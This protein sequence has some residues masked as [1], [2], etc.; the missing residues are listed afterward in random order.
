MIFYCDKISGTSQYK[1]IP[2][3]GYH[4]FK[5][6][7]NIDYLSLLALIHLKTWPKKNQSLKKA[8]LLKNKGSAFLG[9]FL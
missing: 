2:M 6:D 1:M 3:N 9:F 4:L 5:K 7:G 8:E